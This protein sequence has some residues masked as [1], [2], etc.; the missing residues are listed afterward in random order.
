[1]VK[2]KNEVIGNYTVTFEKKQDKV[3]ARI[4]KLTSHYLGMGRTKKEA[5][6][7]IKKT[8]S[9]IYYD[10]KKNISADNIDFDDIVKNYTGYLDKEYEK[11]Q[12]FYKKQI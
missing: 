2:L 4:P 3:L 11:I 10:F 9:Y 1:M 7:Q 6:E 5:F 8:L 12:K